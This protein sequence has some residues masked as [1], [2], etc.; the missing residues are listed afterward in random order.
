ML[1]LLL[2]AALDLDHV[3]SWKKATAHNRTQLNQWLREELALGQEIVIGSVFMESSIDCRSEFPEHAFG[4]QRDPPGIFSVPFTG[5]PSHTVPWTAAQ[6]NP[7]AGKSHLPPC[8]AFR[9]SE[10]TSPRLKDQVSTLVVVI[11]VVVA[12]V[13][14]SIARTTLAMAPAAE[15]GSVLT[16]TV[17]LPLVAKGSS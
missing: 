1:L 4:M 11:V 8:K 9:H 6:S 15:S 3:R 12:L 14:F 10:L 17:I 2:L 16:I 13:T 5:I 7:R